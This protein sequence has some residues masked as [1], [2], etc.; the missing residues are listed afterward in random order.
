MNIIDFLVVLFYIIQ[1]EIGNSNFKEVAYLRVLRP[2]R[3]LTRN[4]NLT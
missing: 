4:P 2:I 3:I 1:M